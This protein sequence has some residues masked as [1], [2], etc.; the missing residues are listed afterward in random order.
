MQ[1]VWVP[2]CESVY[3]SVSVA[4]AVAVSVSL[5]AVRI[6]ICNCGFRFGFLFV[7]LLHVKYLK[8]L[9]TTLECIHS[10]LV[11]ESEGWETLMYSQF[12][13]YS[14]TLQF[15]VSDAQMHR[16]ANAWAGHNSSARGH[17]LSLGCTRSTRI[18]LE[19]TQQDVLLRFR[20]GNH[21]LLS[22]WVVFKLSAC[23]WWIERA[24]SPLPAGE[25]DLCERP[26][27]PKA[28]RSV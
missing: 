15:L 9:R 14:C 5:Y 12:I 11:A 23:W 16:P 22:A 4:V 8:Y 10:L 24:A 13:L 19:R 28:L 1:I 3:I 2:P 18:Q 7:F 25:Y 27:P 17:S 6:C 21:L 26:K 20:L